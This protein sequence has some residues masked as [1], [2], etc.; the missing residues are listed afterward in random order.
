MA[1]KSGSLF[2]GGS[3]GSRSKSSLS[4]GSV[5]GG[6]KGVGGSGGKYF[7]RGSGGGHAGRS[8]PGRTT[9]G[10]GSGP[11]PSAGIPGNKLR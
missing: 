2:T 8:R 7:T 11:S 6:P 3:A 5:Q 4:T 1:Y 9:G 10:R